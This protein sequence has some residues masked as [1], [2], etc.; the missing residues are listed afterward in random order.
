MDFVSAISLAAPD[1]PVRVGVRVVYT[2]RLRE[3]DDQ[4]DHTQY[5]IE[6]VSKRSLTLN[7]EVGRTCFRCTPDC[8][9][10]SCR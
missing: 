10:S 3:V 6:P 4:P 9:S 2:P 8:L 1:N 5:L 7:H